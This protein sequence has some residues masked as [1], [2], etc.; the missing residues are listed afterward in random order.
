MSNHTSRFLYLV[1]LK[2]IGR[3][4]NAHPVIG[5]DVV[6]STWYDYVFVY[7]FFQYAC[8]LILYFSIYLL[9]IFVN[10][11]ENQP[12]SVFVLFLFASEQFAFT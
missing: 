3:K 6:A 1:V 10:I 5:G 8:C 7:T 9:S 2:C 4:C 11:H 12:Q